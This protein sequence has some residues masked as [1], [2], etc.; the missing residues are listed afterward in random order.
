MKKRKLKNLQVSHVSYVE[1]GANQRKFFLTK[2]EEQPNFDKPVK[3]I[4]SDD[5]E[6]RLVYG[7]VYE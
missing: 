3:V 6:K 7:I 5:E 4:K 2:S 1:N